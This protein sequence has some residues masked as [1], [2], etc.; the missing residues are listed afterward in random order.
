MRIPRVYT[1]QALTPG[2]TLELEEGPSH[3]LV[4][5]LRM[6]EGRELRVF[7]GDHHEYRAFINSCSKKVATITVDSVANIT[8]PSPLL[9]E[10]AVGLSKGDRFDF[11]IQK[12]TELG[13]NRIVP[14][15][16]ERS[17]VKL[18]H[19]RTQKK[20]VSWQQ[21]AISACEQCQRNDIPEIVLPKT[22]E[23]F[24]EQCDSDARFVLHHRS[25]ER[26]GS[27]S[28]PQSATLLIGPEGGL[29]DDEI[30]TAERAGFKPL[31]IGPRVMRTETAPIAALALFQY[32]WGD[33]S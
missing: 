31:T 4:K 15:L 26:L 11:I 6:T 13:V 24:V 33:F 28:S 19:E 18:N 9:T 22:L 10:L 3:H 20:H 32:L 2:T 1:T 30:L 16:T 8:Q 21:I 29:S 12:A 14:L 27:E 17:E 5:V 23:D 7:N 25:E